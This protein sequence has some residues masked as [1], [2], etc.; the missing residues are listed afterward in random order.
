MKAL[1]EK[2]LRSFNPLHTFMLLPNFTMCHSALIE[3]I[4]GPNGVY[5]SRGSGTLMALM[6]AS[7]SVES[8]GCQRALCGAADSAL[9]PLT[10]AE[11]RREGRENSGLVP[12]EGAAVL[13]L[14]HS[15]APDRIIVDATSIH[16]G[17]RVGLA[18]AAA[19]AVSRISGEVDSCFIVPWG[20]VARVPLH[21][22]INSRWP[23]IEVHDLSLLIGE[24]LAASPALAWTAAVAKLRQSPGRIAIFSAGIDGDVGLVILARERSL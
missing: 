1:G 13:A 11:L 24:S 15:D 2:G 4:T 14:A 21:T 9:H 19:S 16:P 3:K 17:Q 5:Y 6:E 8:G 18:C 7:Y 20:E 12:S 10:T 22:A 23:A